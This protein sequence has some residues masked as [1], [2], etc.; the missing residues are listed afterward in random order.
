M[1]ALVE[2]DRAQAWAE[3]FSPDYA[4]AVGR[5]REAARRLGAPLHSYPL[6]VRGPQDEAL[7]IDVALIGPASAAGAIVVSSGLHGVEGFFG[8]AVQL[9]CLETWADGGAQAMLADPSPRIALVHAVNPWGFAWR[10]R[11]N[12]VNVDLNRNFL[13]AGE[14]FTGSPPLYGQLDE[15]L[16]PPTPPGLFDL[17]SL[18]AALVEMR[19]GWGALRRTVPIGQYDFPQGLFYGGRGPAVSHRIVAEHV[20][21]WIG[22]ASDV[23]HLDFHSGL[24]TWGTYQLLVDAPSES[25]AVRW[26]RRHFGEE[27]VS[28]SPLA[29]DRDDH[30]AAYAG[31]GT[32]EKWCLREMDPRRY[33]F[34]T[35]EFG[36]YSMLHVLAALRAENRA[37]HWGDRRDA[38][39]RQAS[40]R[41]V[42]AFAPADVHWRAAVVE[43][44]LKLVDHALVAIGSGG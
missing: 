34:A 17:F 26:F 32:W 35:A 1:E 3:R 13:R 40:E 4:T 5:F 36:T 24:G 27:N 20:A 2:A 15:L 21:G 6:E 11:W 30:T 28:A 41:L 18:R 12:E 38:V 22:A 33:R 39:Y 19:H 37:F 29:A 23:I 16:N 25:E 8:S 10:R 44:G 7:S 14:P 43:Q 9:A 42:E 31:R